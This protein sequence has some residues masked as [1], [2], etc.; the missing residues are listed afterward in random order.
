M[1][2]PVAAEGRLQHYLRLLAPHLS[3]HAVWFRNSIRV[4]VALALSML[5]AKMS[6]IEHAFWVVLATLTV[7][8]S[9]VAATGA[10]VVSA[11]IGTFGGFLLATMA[12]LA[13]GSYPVLLWSALP[14][15]V[16]L[17]AYASTAVS[18]GMGQA[19]FALLVVL[20]FNLMLPEGWH[21]GTV[22][23]EAVTVGALAALVA[24]LIMWPKGAAAALRTEV[25]LHVRAAGEL[26]RASFDLVLGHGDA[27]RIEWAGRAC[28]QA[29]QRVEEALAAYAGEKGSNRVPLVVWAPLLQI[30]ISIRVADNTLT[31]LHHAG[32]GVYGCPA[33]ARR[34]AQTVQSLCESLDELA[35]RLEDPGRTPDHELGTLIADLDMVAGDGKRRKEI[36]AATAACLDSSRTDADVM[37]WLIGVTW[38]TLW[39]GYL[40]HLRILTEAPLEEVTAHANA[41]WWR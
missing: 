11:V 7:L 18:L 22:R 41:P 4:G 32:Y 27:A 19:M 17:S 36:V 9:N 21:T 2:E 5:I 28:T 14:L 31:A 13:I 34:V 1:A 25:A 12:T 26:T 33:A 38:A 39:L 8:R 30:P 3:P 24:S 15:A 35:M 10:T 37:H 40:A 23:L 6:G 20:L 16:F 29:R